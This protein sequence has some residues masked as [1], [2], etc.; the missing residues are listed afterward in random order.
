[1]VKSRWLRSLLKL[2][3]LL[4]PAKP[5]R[6][7]KAVKAVKPGKAAKPTRSKS[8][9]IAAARA[10]VPRAAPA[11]AG[12]WLAAHYLADGVPMRR[13]AYW[14]YLPEAAP[15][16]EGMPLLVMLHGCEQSATEFAQGTR[17]NRLAGDQ[18]YAVL[19]PQQALRAHPQRCWKWYDRATQQGGGDAALIAGVIAQVRSRYPIDARRM[20]IAGMS[21]GAGMAHIV[22]LNQ[23]GLFA[24]LG[25]HS[26]PSFGAGHGM[27]GA[28]AVMQHGAALRT[29]PAIAALQARHPAFPALPT[30]LVQGMDDAVVRPVN[31]AQ[32]AQQ[33]LMLNGLAPPALGPAQ[34]HA[35]TQ[36]THA[37]QLRDAQRQ[38]Q[39]LLRV[40]SID[41]LGHAWSGGDASLPYNSARGPDA[42]RM[43]LA[44]FKRQRR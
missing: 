7:S 12:K 21:S 39:L 2:G 19:Y 10:A 11:A 8:T 3:T 36:R 1:M 32:L 20:Y 38:R 17:M 25:L 23:P 35:A 28:L 6:R 22:A 26:S 5:R 4:Q 30:M 31:Q 41:G 37:Y 15:R 18:G 33:A 29:G 13:M 34:H 24:G 16:P 43:L 44:F 27:A 9:A 40:L 14:L 42:S